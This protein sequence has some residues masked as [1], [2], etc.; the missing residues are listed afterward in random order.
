MILLDARDLGVTLAAPLFRHLDLA[1]SRGDRIGLV[2]A[3]G[4]GK[5]TLLR[6]LAGLAEPTTGDVVH[7]SGLVSGL[8]P[9]EVPV[10]LGPM[11]LRDAV[12]GGLGAGADETDAWRADVVLDDLAV[13]WE[14]R[15]RPVGALSGG[16]R[17]MALLARAWVGE[18]DV[19]LLDEPTNHLDLARIGVLQRW[20]ATVARGVPL[21]AAS[22]DRAFLDAATNRTLFLRE[23]RSRAFALPYT[24]ARAAL[25][26]ADAADGRRFETEMARAAGL[27]RQAAKLKNIGVNS[28]SDL[29][30]VKTKQLRGRAERIEAAA[31][32]AHRERSAGA[33]RLAGDDTHARSLVSLDDAAVTAPDGTPLFRTGRLWIERGD[34]VVVLGPN[35]AGKTRLMSLVVEAL[36]AEV[37]GVRVAPSV[38]PGVSDQELSQLDAFASPMDAVTRGADM[39]DRTARTLLAGAGM[40]IDLQDR[41][42]AALSGG[43]RA[44]L[45]MLLLRLARPN[46]YLLDEPTNHLDVE[47]QEALE[48]E[49]T[50][51]GATALLITHDRAFMRAVGTRFWEI[52]GRR[53]VEVDD[54]E[55]FIEAQTQD[56]A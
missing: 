27:R 25:D 10:E 9:Q 50:A 19:L 48:V 47:G 14:L 41:P 4:R 30:T 24:P 39:G 43:Q 35:G 33:I 28:G 1:L 23:E 32:P 2:A 40:G 44:R 26:E 20:L 54:P 11:P 38:V 52:R 8:V 18:P 5:S 22:H 7:A 6:V 12:L 15:D 42:V 29:L 17:R 45:A 3:N 16:W 49:L 53:L 55:A 46:L 36:T 13:P 37:P 56:E 21:I 51:H 34:R 31:R